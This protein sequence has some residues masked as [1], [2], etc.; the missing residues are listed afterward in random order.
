[1]NTFTQQDLTVEF[2]L[3]RY[4]R[5]IKKLK[6]GFIKDQLI[7]VLNIWFTIRRYDS[8]Q[9]LIGCRLVYGSL[10]ACMG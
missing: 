4:N 6:K 10:Q 8:T 1:M 2:A 7:K 5:H 9:T 3:I